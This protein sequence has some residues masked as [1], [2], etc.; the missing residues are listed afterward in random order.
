MTQLHIVVGPTITIQP[1]SVVITVDTSVTLNCEGTGL[2]SITYQWQ[3]YNI[4][5]G[6]WMNISNS[7]TTELVVE[8]LEQS[9]QYR[10]VISDE[11]GSTT[12]DNATVT[13]LSKFFYQPY[14]IFICD[15]LVIEIS[16]HPVSITDVVALEE[17]TL[18]CSAS[19]DGVTYSWHHVDDDDL[20]SGSTGQQSDTFTINRVT[21]DDE[22]MYYCVAR[23]NGISVTSNNATIVVD[24][25]ELS[26]GIPFTKITLEFVIM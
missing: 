4:N 8:K 14:C 25:K 17:V 23:K 19:V 2:G 24:G 1:A 22:G 11:D 18:H 5:G 16:T 7:N 15:I 26:S 21:P 10:C 20:P 3:N 9:Q 12:S 13:V 6:Q